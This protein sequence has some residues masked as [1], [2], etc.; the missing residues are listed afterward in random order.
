MALSHREVLLTQRRLE[1]LQTGNNTWIK[2]PLK[3][4]QLWKSGRWGN[5]RGQIDPR[6][7]LF[8]LLPAF[9]VWARVTHEIFQGENSLNQKKFMLTPQVQIWDSAPPGC[10]IHSAADNSDLVHRGS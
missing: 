10:H 3:L 7:L 6:F 1:E 8:T 2:F 5:P 9:C 4:L